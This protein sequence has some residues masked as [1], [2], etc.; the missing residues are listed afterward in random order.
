MTQRA[1]GTG[2]L[3]T[4]GIDAQ[5]PYMELGVISGMDLG[6]L[7]RCYF[8]GQSKSRIINNT[9]NKVNLYYL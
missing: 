4:M 3:V 8:Q 7:C 5:K 9:R 6:V 2:E 1:P